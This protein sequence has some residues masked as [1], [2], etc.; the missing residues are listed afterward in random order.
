MLKKNLYVIAEGE[1]KISTKNH[2]YK[3]NY[4]LR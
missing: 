2:L 1:E 3:L 4:F